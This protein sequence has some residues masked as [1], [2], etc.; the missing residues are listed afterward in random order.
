MKDISQSAADTQATIARIL[1]SVDHIQEGVAELKGIASQI[2]GHERQLGGL[3]AQAGTAET[4][5]ETVFRRIDELREFIQSL[6]SQG[7]AE[8]QNQGVAIKTMQGQLS[9]AKGAANLGWKVFSAVQGVII[10]GAMY[11]VANLSETKTDVAV[12]K[13]RSYWTQREHDKV[14][15]PLIKRLAP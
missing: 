3:V 5:F 15:D 2:G 10:A 12:L 13:E 7:R 1:Q 8:L 9:E 11:V 14:I 6:D 4:R